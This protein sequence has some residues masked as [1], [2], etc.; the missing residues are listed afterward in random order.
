MS[1][2]PTELKNYPVQGFATGDVVPHMV[3][4]IV[5][6]LAGAPYADQ[7]LPIMTVHDS[8][9]FDVHEDVVDKFVNQCYNAL[10][11][12]TKIVNDYFNIDLPIVLD[13]GC[14]VGLNWLDMKEID[15]KKGVK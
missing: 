3:G 2:S 4:Y 9:L 11:N 6:K 7:A 1:F 8:I 15:F 5:E 13:V 12:T 14:K 10:K